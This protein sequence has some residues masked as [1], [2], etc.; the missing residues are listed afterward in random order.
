MATY[1]VTISTADETALDN[2]L[3]DKILGFKMQLQAR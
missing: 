1:T 2:D 3:L